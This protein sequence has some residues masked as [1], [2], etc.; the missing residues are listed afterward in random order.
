MLAAQHSFKPR[1]LSALPSLR[2]FSYDRS[3]IKKM[4][5]NVKRKLQVLRMYTELKDFDYEPPTM[6]YDRKTGD[7]KITENKT[8]AQKEAAR[9]EGKKVITSVDDLER[10]KL[11]LYAE[12]GLD[13]NGR[14]LKP[15]EGTDKSAERIRKVQERMMRDFDIDPRAF[16]V[17]SRDMMRVDVGL[18]I[19]RPPIF[20]TMRDR[21]VQ[22]LKYKADIMNEYYCN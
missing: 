1:H 14:P 2:S 4:E 18:L 19:Q 5:L 9:R 15:E 6:S 7:I 21:D 3:E 13:T 10:E 17:F 16:Q 8:A 20:M 12:E 22:F 11:A